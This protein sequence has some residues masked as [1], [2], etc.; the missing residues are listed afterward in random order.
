[1]GSA[2]LNAT[3]YGPIKKV[4]A[5]LKMEGQHMEQF[6]KHKDKDKKMYGIMVK[7][8]KFVMHC[9]SKVLVLLFG[10]LGHFGNVL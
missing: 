10:D 5:T 8:T 1:M 2:D 6:L 9:L 7:V 3:F 4:C